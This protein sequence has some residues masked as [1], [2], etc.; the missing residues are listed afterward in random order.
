MAD[1]A[2]EVEAVPL[3]LL[4]RKAQAAYTWVDESPL[5]GSDPKLQS[6]VTEGLA[7][8]E[9]GLQQLAALRFGTLYANRTRRR[10]MRVRAE[11]R[12]VGLHARGC[13]RARPLLPPL[14]Q[15]WR[16]LGRPREAPA[17]T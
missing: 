11:G 10:R 6:R 7:T 12:L 14:R 8:S 17:E 16:A 15:R 1:E 5:S 2:E 9:R 13:V 3:S 4:F